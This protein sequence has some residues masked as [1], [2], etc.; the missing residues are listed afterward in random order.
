MVSNRATHHRPDQ[1]S[2]TNDLKMYSK[3]CPSTHNDVTSFESDGMEQNIRSWMSQ[4]PNVTSPW[5][6]RIPKF[7]MKD[8]IVKSYFLAEV[9]DNPL[10]A[11]PT[12]WS[13]TLKRSHYLKESIFRRKYLMLITFF[14][15]RNKS[16]AR[17]K[18]PS[19]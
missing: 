12:K 7:C 16:L 10:N 18:V 5:N 13:N 9:T 11:N 17:I 14:A 6:K 1:V 2:R 19:Q 3:S 8:Y 15:F 4:E